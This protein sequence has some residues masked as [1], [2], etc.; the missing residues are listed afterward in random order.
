MAAVLER[1][2]VEFCGFEREAGRRVREVTVN[3]GERETDPRIRSRTKPWC[4][5]NGTVPLPEFHA[6]TLTSISRSVML[7]ALTCVFTHVLMVGVNVSRH[8]HLSR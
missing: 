1:S 3:P 8:L 5:L 6:L 2:F 7:A 4:V